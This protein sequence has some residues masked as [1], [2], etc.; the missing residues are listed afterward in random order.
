MTDQSTIACRWED[1]EDAAEFLR[2]RDQLRR[3]GW[4]PDASR[5]ELLRLVTAGEVLKGSGDE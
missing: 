1:P 5:D 2:L 3:D 4:L